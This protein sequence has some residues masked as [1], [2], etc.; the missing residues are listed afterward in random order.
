MVALNEDVTYDADDGTEA[1]CSLRC[2]S[3]QALYG[4]KKTREN[5]QEY[6]E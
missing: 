6:K 2:L 5:R 1:V 4:K 3:R